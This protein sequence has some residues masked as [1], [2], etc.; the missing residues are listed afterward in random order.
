MPYVWIMLS[1]AVPAALLVTAVV[2]SYREGSRRAV[3]RETGAA[4]FGR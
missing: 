1:I 3:S 2:N 4:G